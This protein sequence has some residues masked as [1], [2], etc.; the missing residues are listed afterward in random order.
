[1][2]QIISYLPDWIVYVQA[3]FAMFVPL[4]MRKLFSQVHDLEDK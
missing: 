1:M 3:F 4:I 2:K